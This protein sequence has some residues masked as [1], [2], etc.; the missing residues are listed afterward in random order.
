MAANVFY[1]SLGMFLVFLLQMPVQVADA[2]EPVII[3]TSASLPGN[4]SELSFFYANSQERS[5][6]QVKES[7]Y[8][9]RAPNTNETI[10]LDGAVNKYNSNST[11][12]NKTDDNNLDNLKST[13]S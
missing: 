2:G 6:A 10:T 12:Q 1:A 5:D 4:R 7:I 9:P 13:S 3:R 11:N 8:T